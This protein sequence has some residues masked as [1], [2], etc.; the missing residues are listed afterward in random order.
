MVVLQFRHVCT[1]T[2]AEAENDDFPVGNSL[3][4]HSGHLNVGGSSVIVYLQSPQVRHEWVTPY[5][6][7]ICMVVITRAPCLQA[8]SLDVLIFDDALAR[9][10]MVCESVD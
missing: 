3:P 4:E 10:C 9:H 7:S 1:Q 2:E 6:S 5:E 8:M